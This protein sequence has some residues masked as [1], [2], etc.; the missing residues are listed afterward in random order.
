MVKA[1]LQLIVM[2]MS[3]FEYATVHDPGAAAVRRLWMVD[4]SPAP[5]Y[6]AEGIVTV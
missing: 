3:A 5:S 4:A 2:L 1:L 6:C